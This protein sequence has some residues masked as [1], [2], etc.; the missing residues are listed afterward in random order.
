MKKLILILTAA[1]V[2]ASCAKQ[3]AIYK[4]F[5][6]EGGIIYPAKPINVEARRGYQ[7]VVLKWDAPMDPSLRTVKVFWDGTSH[8]QEFNYADYPGG[9]IETVVDNLEDRS[10]TFSIVN[11]DGDGNKSLAAEIT[12]SPF[13]ESWLVSHAERTVKFVRT[14]GNDAVVTMNKPTDE[15]A[16]TKFRYV[17]AQGETV[18]AGEVRADENEVRLPGAVKNKYIEYQ[19][20]F[21]SAEGIDTVWTGNWFRSDDPVAFRVDDFKATVTSSAYQYRDNLTPDK[22]IDGI[23][24]DGDHRWFSSNASQYRSVWPKILVIDTKEGGDNVMTFNKFVFYQDPD[25]EGQTRRYIRSVNIYVSNTKFNP[26]DANY[27]KNYGDPVI[28]VSLNQVDAVQEF[29]PANKPTGRYVAIVFRNSYNSSGFVDLW[30][31]EAFGFAAKL[32][33]Q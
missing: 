10:Y 25:P 7:R 16:L 4:Q 31:F 20:A 19:S 33:E 29:V 32:A 22:I 24:D 30:E 12:T 11:Y 17:N 5:I 27:A 18:E 26:D 9:S 21:C 3:D 1:L 6:K 8:S 23:Y 14:D 15:V 2:L 28:S 13:G